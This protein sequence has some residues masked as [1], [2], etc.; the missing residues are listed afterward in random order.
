MMATKSITKI[1]LV[2]KINDTDAA[3]SEWLR[4][5]VDEGKYCP[6]YINKVSWASNIAMVM[7][8]TDEQAIAFKLC[9]AESNLDGPYS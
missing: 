9:F 3:I 4:R 7:T 2:N 8:F 1:W 5:Y 6:R